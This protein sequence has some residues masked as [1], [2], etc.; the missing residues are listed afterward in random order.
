M[1]M[2]AGLLALGGVAAVAA[3][4]HGQTSAGV[5]KVR[6][7]GDGHQTRVVVELDRATKGNVIADGAIGKSTGLA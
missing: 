2:V 7:G 6:L 4:S 1:R 3:V 5:L